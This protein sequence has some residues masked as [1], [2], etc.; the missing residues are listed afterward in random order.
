M[1]SRKISVAAGTK[2][3]PSR[4]FAL[5]SSLSVQM[6]PSIEHIPYNA[7]EGATDITIIA[8]I[9]SYA[10]QFADENKLR[11]IEST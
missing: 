3:I 6:P 7:F 4:M 11:F 2:R 9:G 10:N 5:A 8:E 1:F